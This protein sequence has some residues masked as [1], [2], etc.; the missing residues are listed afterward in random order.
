MDKKHLAVRGYLTIYGTA[1]GNPE[2]VLLVLKSS[3]PR[4]HVQWYT[5][6]IIINSVEFSTKSPRGIVLPTL[7]LYESSSSGDLAF[8]GLVNSL[9]SL[10]RLFSS[11]MF[12]CILTALDSSRFIVGF[13]G[14]NR[15]VCRADVTSITAINQRL[16]YLTILVCV[17][18]LGYAMTPGLG[19]LVANTDLVFYGLSLNKFTSPR[20]IIVLSNVLTI[21][22]IL[23]VYDDSVTVQDGPEDE[24]EE[25]QSIT[26]TLNQ[27]TLMPDR[28]VHIDISIIIFLIFNTRGIISVFE[29][30]NVPLSAKR[31]TVTQRA[32]LQYGCCTND[33]CWSQY[34]DASGFQFYL[35][36]IG[37]LSY[38]A[39][40]YFH[41]NV[42]DKN[43]IHLGF[44]MVLSGN[45]LLVL[46]SN[47]L[48]FPQLLLA[49]VGCP[50]STTIVLVVFSKLLDGRPLGT[51]RLDHVYLA[52]SVTSS[53]RFHAD[54]R[55]F[56]IDIVLCASSIGLFWWYTNL[57]HETTI[58]LL[59]YVESAYQEESLANT[60]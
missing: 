25:D 21:F 59:A 43:W 47:S 20:M 51:T 11:T 30:V 33:C 28:I 32:S 46:V 9:L 17:V 10:G 12:S 18:D 19:S 2:C 23:T 34:V 49:D 31:P 15:C 22:G 27:S 44:A 54:T 16:P 39:I 35:V 42:R 52:L 14:G 7:F 45:P 37:L 24:E 56:W 40:E 58:K 57:V 38:V 41:H 26:T 53:A 36:V 6:M 8:M 55:V 48:N 4:R 60:L 1:T 3:S 13:G 5:N 50:I 29:T